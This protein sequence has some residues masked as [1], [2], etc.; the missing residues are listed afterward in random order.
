MSEA[1]TLIVRLHDALDRR[2]LD[3][4]MRLFHP[5]VRFLDYLDGGELVGL[6][7]VRA[8][9]Q[10]LFETMAPAVDLLT[11]TDLPDGRLSTELQVSIHDHSGHLWSDTRVTATYTVL[12]DLIQAVELGDER[13]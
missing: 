13:R 7:A 8:F 5:D 12:E 2:D 9:Y 6:A 4:L 11:V 3:G 10:R 1:N